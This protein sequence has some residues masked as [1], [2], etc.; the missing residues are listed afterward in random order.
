M[1][2]CYFCNTLIFIFFIRYMSAKNIMQ[3]NCYCLMIVL[4]AAF[5]T[6]NICGCNGD[7]DEFNW[8]S[9]SPSLDN[10]T[11]AL[12]QSHKDNQKNER[13]QNNYSVRDTFVSRNDS[14][15]NQLIDD[16]INTRREGRVLSEYNQV[17]ADGNLDKFLLNGNDIEARNL[18]HDK[19]CSLGLISCDVKEIKSK[20]PNYSSIYAYGPNIKQK[21]PVGSI[22]PPYGQA[23][24]MP[25]SPHH[26]LKG[27]YPP[28]PINT[29]GPPRKVDFEG[30]LSGKPLSHYRPIPSQNKQHLNGESY[31]H[32]EASSWPNIGLSKPPGIDNGIIYDIKPPQSPVFK[33]NSNNNNLPPYSFEKPQN[34]PKGNA[35]GMLQ[36]HVHHHYHHVENNHKIMTLPTN[37]GEALSTDFSPLTP[38]PVELTPITSNQSPFYMPT[39]PNYGQTSIFTNDFTSSIPT[40]SSPFSPLNTANSLGSL[41]KSNTGQGSYATGF[42]LYLSNSYYDQNSDN[43]KKELQIDNNNLGYKQLISSIYNSKSSDYDPARNQYI[44]CQCVL[45]NQCPVADRVGRKEDLILAIDPRN[46][47]KDIIAIPDELINS[48]DNSSTTETST[49]AAISFNLT[50]QSTNNNINEQNNK[51]GARG[52]RDISG[53]DDKAN[54]F[55]K[56]INIPLDG[57]GVS[58]Y[59]NSFYN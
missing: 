30:L 25:V 2:K 27:S 20:R 1:L 12:Q 11:I 53:I 48:G 44:D 17:Y 4:I 28:R 55:D 16:I 58:E 57:E 34:T 33:E 9:W 18:V 21:Y 47:A 22:Y 37:N 40:L 6:I 41:N 51:S 29:F 56:I 8:K 43:Y 26:I 10:P 46:L 59:S 35:G 49:I 52:K 45:Y 19:L 50:S 36:Q 15:I 31:L 5:L 14:D 24:P 42:D 39:S 3:K 54:D 13:S 38:S 23:K 32:Q 7:N